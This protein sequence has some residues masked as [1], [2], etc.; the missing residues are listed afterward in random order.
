MHLLLYLVANISINVH[1]LHGSGCPLDWLLI[2]A[3]MNFV[4]L[5][6]HLSIFSL[7]S[8]F[9]FIFSILHSVSSQYVLSL[10]Y[11]ATNMSSA[12]PNTLF[13][14]LNISF[15]FCGTCLLLGQYQ[16]VILHNCIYQTDCKFCHALEVLSSFR[17]WHPE[18][19]SGVYKCKITFFSVV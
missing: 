18:L 6:R 3:K 4:H 13:N 19:V 16:S 11:P 15:I 14:S 12:M 5:K 9:M 8:S 10:S 7:K 17:L 2:P 1:N